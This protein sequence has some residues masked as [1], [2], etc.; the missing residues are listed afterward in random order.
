[1]EVFKVKNYFVSNTVIPADIRC[2]VEEEDL[3][4]DNNYHILLNP[5]EPCLAFGDIDHCETTEQTMDILRDVIKTFDIEPN[6]LSY[7][8]SRKIVEGK[9]DYG[10]HWVIPSIKCKNMHDLKKIMVKTLNKKHGDKVDIGIYKKSW[11][12]LPEQTTNYA[13]Y[14]DKNGVFHE[15]EAKKIYINVVIKANQ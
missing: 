12:R 7:T 1:M 2:K 4:K 9:E 14:T 8:E 13:S 5:D 15:V 11:F 6:E 10:S 3:K